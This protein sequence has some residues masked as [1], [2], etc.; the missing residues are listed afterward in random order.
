MAIS[1]PSRYTNATTRQADMTQPMLDLFNAVT[2]INAGASPKIIA[3]LDVYNTVASVGTPSTPTVLTASTINVQNNIGFDTAT[4][5]ITL[6]QTG[7]YQFLFMLNAFPIAVTTMFYGAEVDTGSGFAALPFS[8]R[9]E[10]VNLNIN[11]QLIFFSLNNF[12]AGTRARVYVWA[13]NA[14]TTFQTTSLSALPGG[15]VSVPA[16]RIMIS[17]E[18]A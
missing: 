6:N 5:I 18:A 3:G 4:G 15:A 2:Q 11:G 17:G 1:L 10:S 7:A 13:S 9:Q 14:T 16:T 12:N 8:G